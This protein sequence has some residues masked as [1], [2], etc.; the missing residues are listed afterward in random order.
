MKKRTHPKTHRIFFAENNVE[1]S[2][3]W[4][5]SQQDFVTVHLE[6]AYY[7][8]NAAEAAPVLKTTCG[9]KF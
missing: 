2:L 4:S 3:A 6:Q 1:I 8:G 5:H 7:A 9:L